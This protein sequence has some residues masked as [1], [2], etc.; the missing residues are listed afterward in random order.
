MNLIFIE[1]IAGSGKSSA[2][3]RLGLHLTSLGASVRWYFG[4]DG[5]HPIYPAGKAQSYD[6]EMPPGERGEIRRSVLERWKR[7]AAL[8]SGT[9]QIVIL[10][11]VLL[12]AVI[13]YYQLLNL[14]IE[15]ASDHIME[16]Q[17]LLESL[18]PLVIYFYQRDA[19]AA[20]L[21]ILAERGAGYAD[22]LVKLYSESPFGRVQGIR[23]CQGVVEAIAATRPV[24]DAIFE[25]LS[26]RKIAIEN[27]EG[28]WERYYRVITDVLRMPPVDVPTALPRNAET[29]VG[30][31]RLNQGD[32]CSV[33]TKRNAMYV[34]NQTRLQLIPES[35][36][37]FYVLGTRWKLEFETDTGGAAQSF[38]LF[39]ST[40]SI[41][42]VWSRI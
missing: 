12:Q 40:A 41:P 26:M 13:D 25:K 20:L 5:D 38:K 34:S 14:E 4:D 36:S 37:E 42:E 33:I 23:D 15:Q 16:V 17:R 35:E 18:D 39:E 9:N 29:F 21:K 24:A 1:G 3:H 27:S 11:G 31:Y 10:E 7:L 28:D 19:S 32:E 2:A 22:L 30:R 6:T 8:I